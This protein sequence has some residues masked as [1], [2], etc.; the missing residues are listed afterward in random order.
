MYSRLR[1]FLS[2]LLLLVNISLDKDLQAWFGRMESNSKI[3]KP[4]GHD[5]CSERTICEQFK[6]F[7][8]ILRLFCPYRIQW[9]KHQERKKNTQDPGR[10]CHYELAKCL[11]PVSAYAYVLLLWYIFV[12][13]LLAFNFGL[14]TAFPFQL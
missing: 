7:I 12:L 10:S 13:V 8:M 9:G 14:V 2:F 3:Q 1:N 4:Q 11:Q 5:L 6:P